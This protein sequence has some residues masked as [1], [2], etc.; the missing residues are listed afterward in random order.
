LENQNNFAYARKQGRTG[1]PS[2]P[3]GKR[4]AC[5][6]CAKRRPTPL[7]SGATPTVNLKTG[8]TFVLKT[9]IS[10]SKTCLLRITGSSA[11][12]WH[13]RQSAPDGHP[14]GNTAEAT[15]RFLEYHGRLNKLLGFYF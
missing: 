7:R 10:N 12:T 4:T 11:F 9:K 6:G 13:R 15:P 2:P 5:L 14:G 1:I 3:V 8:R